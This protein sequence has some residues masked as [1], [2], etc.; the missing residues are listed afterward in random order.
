MALGGWWDDH[1]LPRIVRCA[2]GAEPV[3]A[4][5]RAIVPLAQG[6]V[7]ELGCG[8][9]LNQPHYQAHQVSS[10]AGLDPSGKLL[11]YARAQAARKG[12]QADI[13]HGFGEDIPFEDASFDTVVCTFTLCSVSDHAQSLR[14]MRRILRP[15]G[16][17]LFGEHGR[18][19]HPG[20]ARW[21]DRIEPLW[22]RTMGNCHL[23]R[24]IASAIAQAGF[25]TEVMDARY[26]ELGPRWVS[27]MEWGRAVK[28][29]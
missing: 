17:L 10:F 29:G 7:F 8:G 19:P 20:V 6:R 13:R 5:R 12:W 16:V 9:G 3:A 11:D 14:E 27:W 26:T 25:A 2:C 28:T 1:V 23:S 24:P 4:I 22:R 21:Q 15:G 18:A